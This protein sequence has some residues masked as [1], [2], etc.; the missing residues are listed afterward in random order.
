M[1]PTKPIVPETAI[2]SERAAPP[3]NQIR[4]CSQNHF[5]GGAVIVC[6]ERQSLKLLPVLLIMGMSNPTI[7]P[8]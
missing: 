6:N 3:D 7:N 8:N 4:L 1:S 5:L 2:L